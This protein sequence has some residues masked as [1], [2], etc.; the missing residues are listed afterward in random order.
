MNRALGFV[1]SAM[2]F[3]AGLSGQYGIVTPAIFA[4]R[5]AATA[6][7]CDVQLLVPE[8]VGPRFG[9]D[10]DPTKIE[11]PVSASDV[12]AESAESSEP[13]EPAEPVIEPA[14][15]P[16]KIEEPKPQPQPK[17]QVKPQAS[18]P[19][20]VD[21]VTGI[22]VTKPSIIMLTTPGCIHCVRWW[23]GEFTASGQ[24]KKSMRQQFKDKN[25]F[26]DSHTG[27]AS[28]Y[29]TFR[30]YDGKRWH[31]HVGF[32]TAADVN[33]MLSTAV[34][35]E[36]N[37]SQI[38]ADWGS[39]PEYTIGGVPWTANSLRNHLYTHANHRYASGSLDQLSLDELRKLHNAEHKLGKAAVQSVQSQ[40]G[41][42]V[43][44]A[45]DDYCPT[46]PQ[47]RSYQQYSPGIFRRWGRR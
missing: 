43:S 8:A 27:S 23:D 33:R 22:R 28:R 25:W 16:T 44:A 14:F 32:M 19:A 7:S 11:E 31:T 34:S 42:A 29:P 4:E 9:T 13:A 37:E 30:V 39:L 18:F 40:I 26:V 1:A 5:E 35:F 3:S 41:K 15:D 12:I 6:D 46:C 20:S 38:G 17:P 21:H 45:T 36:Q 2:L 24:R 47:Q 10:F